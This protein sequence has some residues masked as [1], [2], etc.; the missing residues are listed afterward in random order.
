MS[1]P[2]FAANEIRLLE[3]EGLQ[4]QHALH[5]EQLEVDI[6][7]KDSLI[8][9]LNEEGKKHKERLEELEDEIRSL[10]DELKKCEKIEELEDLVTVVKQKNERIEDLEDALKQSVRI[11]S[12][13]EM[14]KKDEEERRV[15]ITAKVKNCFIYKIYI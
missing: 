10:E 4:R 11:A 3:I 9:S 7:L 12:D 2:S 15:E 13:L 14:E 6:K 5:V 8:E 1:Q